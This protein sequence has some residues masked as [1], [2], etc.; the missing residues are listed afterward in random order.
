M[1]RRKPR[2]VAWWHA[3]LLEGAGVALLVGLM[4]G[5]NRKVAQQPAHFQAQ[6]RDSAARQSPEYDRRRAGVCLKPIGSLQ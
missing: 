2:P 1:R 6:P 4:W 3:V 5:G